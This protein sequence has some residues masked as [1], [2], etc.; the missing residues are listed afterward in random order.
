MPGYYQD[1]G[2]NWIWTAGEGAPEPGGIDPLA[3][4]PAV[5]A[6]APAPAPAA[7]P[8]T[9]Y[10]PS[11]KLSDDPEVIAATA[12]EK[13]GLADMGKWQAPTYIAPRAPSFAGYD[14]QL[15]QAQKD[16]A[17]QQARL[18]EMLPINLSNL[19][20]QHE[21]FQQN[22]AHQ[23]VIDQRTILNQ[24]AAHGMLGSGDLGY[25]TSEEQRAYGLRTSE[26]ARQYGLTTEDLQRRNRWALEDITS[27]LSNLAARIGVSKSEA[28]ANYAESVRVGQMN[29]QN[30]LREF[31]NNKISA[32]RDLHNKVIDA[33]GNAF[34]R[35][36][37]NPALYL[38]TDTIDPKSLLS[39]IP[40][41]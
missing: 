38:G 10:V 26:E 33:Y 19:Q 23:H 14:L 37:E 13:Q 1:S 15:S 27:N 39:Q 34:Q 8:S 11:W 4:P 17:T 16:A 22:A 7:A 6:P 41:A 18:A 24:L 29:Y 5:P 40:T 3:N 12:F 20:H 2:G 30:A 36:I 31:S 28:Q 35:V 21:L 25:R 9:T 32:A